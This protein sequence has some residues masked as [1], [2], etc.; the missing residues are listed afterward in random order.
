MMAR[1]A[2]VSKDV[3][4]LVAALVVTFSGSNVQK[5]NAA[6]RL[7]LLLLFPKLSQAI[8]RSL[9]GLRH[10]VIGCF[11]HIRKWPIFAIET[12]ENQ[13]ASVSLE[14]M[15]R[16]EPSMPAHDRDAHS[17]P[18]DK[19]SSNPQH[20]PPTWPDKEALEIARYAGAPGPLERK[21]QAS[22]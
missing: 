2:R 10:F 1:S 6:K 16:C 12:S 13:Q 20:L 8:F 14:R 22:W 7:I 19:R 15:G 5:A 18:H 11:L 3:C 9:P 4:S 17:R 21:I